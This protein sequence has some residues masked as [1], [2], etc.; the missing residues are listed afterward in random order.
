MRLAGVVIRLQN[1]KLIR[2]SERSSESETEE[3]PSERIEVVNIRRHQ[4][5]NQ[6]YPVN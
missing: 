6:V 5:E 2:R 3:I 1:L 4:D